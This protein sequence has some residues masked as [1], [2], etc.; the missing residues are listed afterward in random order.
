M[1]L[2]GLLWA[3]PVWADLTVLCRA[4]GQVVEQAQAANHAGLPKAAALADAER[5]AAS[6]ELRQTFRVLIDAAY[7]DSPPRPTLAAEVEHACLGAGQ[8]R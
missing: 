8:H 3:G 7:A 4:L 6:P 2:I 5:I 1:G